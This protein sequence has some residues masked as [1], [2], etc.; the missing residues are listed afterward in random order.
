[1]TFFDMVYGNYYYYKNDEST[2]A[3]ILK[4]NEIQPYKNYNSLY[5]LAAASIKGYDTFMDKE[6]GGSDRFLDIGPKKNYTLRPATIKEIMWLD[7]C[8]KE[9]KW[10]NYNPSKLPEN[11][12][13]NNYEIY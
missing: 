12:I 2:I 5:V 13:N 6:E 1:M 11:Q 4:F 7:E 3:Y 9:Q 8:I 10:I